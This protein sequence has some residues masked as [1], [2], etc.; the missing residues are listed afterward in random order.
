MKVCASTRGVIFDCRIWFVQFRL[1][2]FRQIAVQFTLRDLLS[3]DWETLFSSHYLSNTQNP[4]PGKSDLDV[5]RVKFFTVRQTGSNLQVSSAVCKRC[6]LLEEQAKS[7]GLVQ[8]EFLCC[9]SALI[10]ELYVKY[11][12]TLSLLDCRFKFEFCTYNE[13]GTIFTLSLL[14]ILSQM[15]ALMAVPLSPFHLSWSFLS[16]RVLCEGYLGLSWWT[17]DAADLRH[18]FHGWSGE[19]NTVSQAEDL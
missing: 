18:C 14:T 10:S 17:H 6:W 8:S 4:T 3:F 7:R 12:D 16:S 9:S 19:M 11:K 5:K 2:D 13:L 1:H 15:S